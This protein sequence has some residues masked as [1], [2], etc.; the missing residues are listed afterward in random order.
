MCEIQITYN[1]VN[2]LEFSIELSLDDEKFVS[3]QEQDP[4]I[5]EL[6]DK[7]KKGITMNFTSSKKMLCLG[8]CR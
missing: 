8:V 1:N 7:V 6:L 4:R 3:S 5:W 2:N